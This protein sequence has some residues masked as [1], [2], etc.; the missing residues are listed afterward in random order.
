MQWIFKKIH[1]I[2]NAVLNF[3]QILIRKSTRGGC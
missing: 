2:Q 3:L 1:E